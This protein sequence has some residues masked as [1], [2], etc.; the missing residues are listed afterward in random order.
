MIKPPDS[1]AQQRDKPWIIRTYAGHSTAPESNAL[2]RKN[3]AKGQ[4]G[5][6]VAFDLPTQTGYDADHPL[7]N[8][9]VGKVG[10][11]ICHLGDMRALFDQIPLGTMNTSM[12]INA[13]AAWLL[14]LYIAVAEEQGVVRRDLQGTTQND[15]IK[16]YLSRGTY[17]FP[18][19]PSM[20]LT[21][22]VILFTTREL[23]KWN[24]MN[25]CSYHLQEA[26]ATPVQELSFALAT[27]IAVL[28]AV[29]ASSD[30]D[31]AQ[32]GEVVGRISFFVNAGL[33]FITELCKMRAFAE[34]W[35]EI[36]AQR[37]GVADLKQRL[38]RYGV[39]VNSLG[40][41]EQ[42][43][44][45]N[46]YRI[47]IEMLAVTLSKKTR[48]R[49]VQ[50]P[51]WNEALGLPRPWDQQWS[52]RMQQ[53]LAYETD[54]LEYGDIFAGAT[55]I[56]TKVAALKHEAREE[57][58]IILR[59]GGAVAAVENSYMKSQLVESN[60]RRV[61]AIERGDQVVVGVNR[62]T[63]TEPSPLAAGESSIL[64]VP[65]EVERSQVASLRAWRAARDA[66]A[67]AAALADLQ[68]AAQAGRNIME[69]SIACAKAGVTTGEW[70]EVLRRGFGEY[71]AP[72]GVSHAARNDCRGI[73]DLRAEVDRVTR[74][75]GRRPK[76]LVGKPGLD[77]HSNGAEQVAVRARDAGMD[78][79]YDGIRLTPAEIV[80]A[81]RDKNV[82]VVGLSILSGSHMPL[83]ED[84]MTRLRA[85]GLD[86]VPVVVGGIIP[87][88]DAAALKQ[89]G[90]AAVYT[91]KDFELNRMMSD[92][93]RIV[94]RS[95]PGVNP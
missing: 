83:I 34:L 93:L 46:V 44:E 71:R 58:Q 59:M 7:A 49:A 62:F 13:T 36:T 43:P 54:L 67:V 80:D 89:S 65:P 9:E 63:E 69:P 5:L 90:V 19:G 6:S 47:L 48:A 42:Q 3:L 50:L 39:Q 81:A 87:P 86:D 85:A 27:A 68:R 4:T 72:T 16:E 56:E 35:D 30:L 61:E 41:T 31:A 92:V 25:V 22:D 53:I 60:A 66:A 29:K 79:V 70:G 21:R 28:D 75:L 23:P 52:L 45:N 37:Y 8:G 15:I 51:A 84:V 94:E 78:V 18:P 32:F 57:L 91:P 26:G 2:Y 1:A 33:R 17:V 77:G 73:D 38:F 10:V 11:S 20:R 12:T 14:A 76:I 82:H 74:K 55:E 24:P 64:T 88:D 95:T 40:L